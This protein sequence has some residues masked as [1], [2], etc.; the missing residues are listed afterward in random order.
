[1]HKPCLIAF[2]Y[3]RALIFSLSAV[4]AAVIQCF[5]G[6]CLNPGQATSGEP[7]YSF[8]FLG[9]IHYDRAWHHDME[10][11]NKNHPNDTAQIHNY[12]RVTAENTPSL[13]ASISTL[14]KQ[15][16]QPV[17]S[18]LQAGDFTE[19]LC[20]SYEL[21]SLQFEE[22]KTF[23]RSYFD[24]IPFLITKGNHDITGP[25]A[26]KAYNDNILQIGRASCRERV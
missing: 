24:T 19:G 11:V 2:V 8:V 21:Q 26:D 18:I 5:T 9:D 3:R 7:D 1:M 16:H 4:A 20:G 17:F 25:G 15:Q 12:C 22:A 13:F 6:C 14:N 23:V 10:W